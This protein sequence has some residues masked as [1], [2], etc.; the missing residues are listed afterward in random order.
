MLEYIFRRICQGSILCLTPEHFVLF[1]SKSIN[2]ISY[3]EFGPTPE[4][5]YPGTN[6]YK[7]HKVWEDYCK[8][9]GIWNGDIDYVE[10]S[11][12]DKYTKE[13]G[14]YF[15]TNSAKDMVGGCP[16]VDLFEF[17]DVNQG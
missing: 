9:T 11:K 17:Y 16:G 10:F 1:F 3:P 14:C 4:Y 15:V 2:K 8:F 6:D 7:D 13:C 5:V 12:L